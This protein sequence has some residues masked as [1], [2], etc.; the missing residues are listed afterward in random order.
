MRL[1]SLT[2]QNFRNFERVD[3]TPGDEASLIV[4]P[5]GQ[6]KTNLLEAIYLLATLRPLRAQRYAE[7]I[8]CGGARARVKGTLEVQGLERE[9]AVEL[10]PT[11]RESFLDGKPVRVLS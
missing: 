1:L 4:G 2:A 6:G 11:G 3:F 7:L 8:Q 5:N 9:I 10:S